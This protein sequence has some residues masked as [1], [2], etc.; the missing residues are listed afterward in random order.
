MC[1][2]CFLKYQAKFINFKIG[3]YCG[4]AIY[5]Y[6]EAI[7][8]LI[9][10]FKG[11][12]DIE[13]GGLFLEQYL[14]YLRFKYLGYKVVSIPS[15]YLEDTRREFNHVK[16]AFNSMKLERLD[17]LEKIDE[18]KQSNQKH[19]DR[20][21]IK[22]HL[23]VSDIEKVRNK[24]ILIVDDVVTTGSTL[25]ATI[26]LINQGHPKCIKILTLAKVMHH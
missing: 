17:I 13:L 6:D 23:K 7:R 25:K 16:E 1:D 9:Y 21:N 18:Y 14:K 4:L 5:E 20:M 26:D 3:K 19:K 12:Y 10:Q 15:Y 11:C 24:K 2:Q 22:Y 8:E